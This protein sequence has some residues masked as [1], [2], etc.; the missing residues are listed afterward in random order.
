M[1]EEL[2]LVGAR[3]AEAGER[4]EVAQ[5]HWGGGTPTFLSRRGAG[6]AHAAHRRAFPARGGRRSLDRGGPK[7]RPAGTMAQLAALG[8]Q[9][10]LGRRSRNF[11]PR[12]QRAVHR[13]QS[14]ADT[15]RTIE[16]ARA[17][18][19]SLGQPR[20]HLRAAE[21]DGGRLR[22]DAR[23]GA[24][25]LARARRAVQLRAPAEALHAPAPHP[26][27]NLPAPEER[28]SRSSPR[29]SSG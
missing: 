24:R 23:E 26:R 3:L 1:G 19:V 27:R 14:E 12:V 18:R 7:E 2:A 6:S 9:P 25:A 11:D 10:R 28:S 21:A 5:L 17:T 4:P 29:R 20:P 13:V 8:F 22:G 16:E 15:R